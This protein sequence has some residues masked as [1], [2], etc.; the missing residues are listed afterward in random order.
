MA[1]EAKF[2]VG[3]E[4][5]RARSLTPD[6]PRAWR[7]LSWF[8]LVLALA[9]VSDW[10]IAWVPVRLGNPEWEFGTIVASIAGL[11]LIGIGFAGLLA[12]GIARGAK[13][14]TIVVASAAL[15][16]AVLLL[17]ALVVFALDVPL[18][19]SSVQGVARLGIQKAIVK[20][21]I[22]GLLFLVAFGVSGVAALRFA[23]T[24]SQRR[25]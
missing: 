14:Q 12:S 7:W 15:L 10:I 21:T 22:V 5:N 13:S 8:S 1:T 17:G 18:A 19:L 6:A 16:L 25:N 9:G 11:P 23:L 20:T 3:G 24:A 4:P 2:Y